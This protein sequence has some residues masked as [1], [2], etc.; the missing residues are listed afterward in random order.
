MGPV[1]IHN[2]FLLPMDGR[3]V[4]E[5]AQVLVRGAEIL[6]AGPA[7]SLPEGFSP[8]LTIDGRGGVV[9]P[10]LVNCHTHAAMTL[11]R[12]YADDLPLMRWLTEAIW[13]LEDR[14]DGE[15][16]YWGT[17]L[18]CLEMIRGGVTTFA[19]MYFFMDAAARAVERAGL[20]ASLSRG[21]IGNGPAAEKGL[22]ESRELVEKWHGAAGGRITV[23][24]GPHAPYTCPPSY[25]ARVIE[26]SGELGVGIHIHVAETLGEM[27]E[28]KEKYGT[29]PVDLLLKTGLLE[30]PVLAAHCVHA[31]PEDIAVLADKKVG[32]AHN[33]ESNMKL[34]S[35]IAPVQDM[36]RAGVRVGLGTDGAASNNDQDLFGE[37]RSAAM[38]AKVAAMD[39]TVLPASRVLHMATAG[40]A[41][42]L[43]LSGTGVLAPGRKADL[44]LI[45]IHQ[46]HLIPRHDLSGHLVYAARASDVALTMV[47]GRVLWMDGRFTTLDDEEIMAR[48]GEKA[49]RLA[50]TS[51]K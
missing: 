19:D 6:Y 2:V 8:A 40:G 1:L 31:G 34:G 12:S 28:I 22:A 29:T 38:L 30:R 32:V 13:P 26:L 41:A 3:G 5:D 7:A 24:L 35:G 37:M 23:M 20:R 47:D 4:V 50:G 9:M 17:L 48:A 45:D 36:L 21:L 15:D 18:A 44:V 25:L 49:A 11:L 43:G 42:A 27:A 51:L 33:P 14:M 39:P 10:G 46:P 16:I